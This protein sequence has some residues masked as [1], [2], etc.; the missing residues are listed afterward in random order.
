MFELKIIWQIIWL[1]LPLIVD[2]EYE[3]LCMCL[4]VKSAYALKR[5]HHSPSRHYDHLYLLG[6]ATFWAHIDKF[7]QFENDKIIEIIALQS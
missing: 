7:I 6:G 4:C 3:Y 1:L 2:A 5:A